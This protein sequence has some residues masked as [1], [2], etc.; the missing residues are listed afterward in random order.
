[1]KA[2]S[3]YRSLWLRF[4]T[5]LGL[6]A[7]YFVAGKLGL[8][9]A[10]VHRSATAVWM[11]SGISLA[12]LIL[13]GYRSWPAIFAGAFLVNFTTEGS[14]ATCLGIAAGNTLEALAGAWVV[15]RFAGGRDAFL[16]PH[17]IFKFA[18]L[19]GIS[20]MIAA[21]LG[22]T[23][24]FVTGYADGARPGQIWLTWWHRQDIV[25]AGRSRSGRRVGQEQLGRVDSGIE[26]PS[27]L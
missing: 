10:F 2:R 15:K 1:M 25:Q 11:P 24:L 13:F 14:I 23:S 4:A 12:A 7:T 26:R 17:N 27:G 3:S 9:L 22:T 18:L 21:T 6:A 8:R 20:T 19:A 5:L 16:H